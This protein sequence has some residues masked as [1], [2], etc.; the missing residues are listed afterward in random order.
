MP[1][2]QLLG[3]VEAGARG[4]RGKRQPSHH[5]FL[6]EAVFSHADKGLISWGRWRVCELVIWL[7][8]LRT[9]IG[10]SQTSVSYC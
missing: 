7:K 5:V 10:L 4:D 1:T 9:G 8:I 2:L 6:S 3:E